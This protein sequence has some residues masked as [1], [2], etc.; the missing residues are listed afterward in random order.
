VTSAGRTFSIRYASVPEDACIA[1]ATRTSRGSAFE[2]IQVNGAAEVIGEYT[3]AQAKNDCGSD[4][5][6]TIVWTRGS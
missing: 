5:D 4:K 1:L 2:K 6:N 3:A